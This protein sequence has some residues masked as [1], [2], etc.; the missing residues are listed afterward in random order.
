VIFKACLVKYTLQEE[1]SRV[2][3]GSTGYST[4]CSTHSWPEEQAKYGQFRLPEQIEFMLELVLALGFVLLFS[5]VA[6]VGPVIFCLLVFIIQLRTSAYFLTTL[7]KRP[8]PRSSFGIGAWEDI[9]AL[10]MKIGIVFSAFL[11]VNFDESFTDAR[12]AT[13]LMGFIILSLL[14]F[15]T[16]PIVDLCCPAEDGEADLLARRRAYTLTKFNKKT[17]HIAKARMNRINTH[18]AWSDSSPRDSAPVEWDTFPHFD[19]TP[20]TRKSTAC[21]GA[22]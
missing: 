6:T 22:C 8:M 19:G 12:H 18:A 20:V 9:V 3:A 15:S 4:D 21:S 5:S 13:R 10:L 2:R 17:G 1:S 16:W 7:S 14:M 11:V